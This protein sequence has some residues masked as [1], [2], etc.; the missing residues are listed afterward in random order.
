MSLWGQLPPSLA[1]LA[2]FPVSPSDCCFACLATVDR[3][4]ALRVCWSRRHCWNNN[5]SA[6]LYRAVFQFVQGTLEAQCKTIIYNNMASGEHWSGKAHSLKTLWVF[7]C[8]LCGLHNVRNVEWSGLISSLW[9]NKHCTLQVGRRH[10][11]SVRR[12]GDSVLALILIIHQH[13]SDNSAQMPEIQA[14]VLSRRVLIAANWCSNTSRHM[15][16]VVRTEEAAECFAAGPDYPGSLC[17]V[18][19]DKRVEVRTKRIFVFL[20]LHQK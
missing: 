20:N 10:T 6:C 14:Q 16:T 8:C 18:L 7:V 13:T 17:S 9:Y 11:N 1:A 19:L 5:R 3:Y 4:S 2:V 12:D 15:C